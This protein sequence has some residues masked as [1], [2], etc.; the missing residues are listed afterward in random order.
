MV[1]RRKSLCGCRAGSLRESEHLSTLRP[2]RALRLGKPRIFDLRFAV[3]DLS[4]CA[5][6]KADRKSTIEI[7][8]FR[9]EPPQ[10]GL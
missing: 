1:C 10:Q 9:G 2:R 6:R 7:R 3:V 8:K 4:N 5:Q